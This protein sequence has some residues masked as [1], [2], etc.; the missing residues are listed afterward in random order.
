M[1]APKEKGAVVMFP[2]YLMH[3]ITPVTKG[4]RKSLVLW[5]GGNT[6]R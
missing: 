3:R 5:V 4:V 2:S 6:F 1:K